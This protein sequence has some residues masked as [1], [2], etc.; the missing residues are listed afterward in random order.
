MSER[1]LF[2]ANNHHVLDCGPPPEIPQG[3]SRPRYQ[4]YFENSH[5]E[6]AVFWSTEPDHYELRMGDCGWSSKL[7]LVRLTTDKLLRHIRGPASLPAK[8]K[9]HRS[10]AAQLLFAGVC[11]VPC[12]VSLVRPETSLVTLVTNE[13]GELM[14]INLEERAWVDACVLASRI[15]LPPLDNAQTKK[16]VE[17]YF[18]RL[19]DMKESD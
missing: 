8:E 3:E 11:D 10:L 14:N 19:S 4:S 18:E 12:H 17:S 15:N 6:Q 13:A 2:Y 9:S 1:P 7:R 16:F 5:G